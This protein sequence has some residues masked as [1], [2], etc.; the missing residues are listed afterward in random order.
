M[1]LTSKSTSHTSAEEK[2]NPAQTFFLAVMCNGLTQTAAYLEIFFVLFK[3][4]QTFSHNC[5]HGK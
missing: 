4:M 5:V 2:K 3:G 1:L